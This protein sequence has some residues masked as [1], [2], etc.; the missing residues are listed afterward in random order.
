MRSCIV[1]P[2]LV[3]DYCKKRKKYIFTHFLPISYED[4]LFY[5]HD[6]RFTIQIHRLK[7]KYRS[8][9]YDNYLHSIVLYEFT[10]ISDLTLTITEYLDYSINTY[11]YP[12]SSFGDLHDITVDELP[13]W[14]IIAPSVFFDD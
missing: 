6:A 8:L 4:N 1:F 12:C 5:F 2:Y 9:I 14:D 7:S 13:S 10:K 11:E 3:P